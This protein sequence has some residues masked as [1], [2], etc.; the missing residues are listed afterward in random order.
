MS[1]FMVLGALPL[2]LKFRALSASG[3]CFLLW[4]GLDSVDLSGVASGHPYHTSFGV[5]GVD[6]CYNV[7][8]AQQ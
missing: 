4:M 5:L 2:F 7:L 1:A 8:Q 6:L 3:L